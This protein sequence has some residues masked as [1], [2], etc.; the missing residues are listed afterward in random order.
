[1][2]R[3]T[4]ACI[5]FAVFTSFFTSTI[6]AEEDQSIRQLMSEPRLIVKYHTSSMPSTAD[7]RRSFTKN[8]EQKTGTTLKFVRNMSGAAQVFQ[9]ESIP[10][11]ASVRDVIQQISSDPRVAYVEPD[12]I[13]RINR[14]PN[15]PRYNEQ[16]HYF[17][18][19][20]GLNLP[21]AWDITTGSSDVVVA[22]IDTGSRPHADLAGQWVP[23]YDFIS[24]PQ[25]SVDGDGRDADP[26][27][28]GDWMVAG[29]CDGV[30]PPNDRDSSW[31]GTHV[32][33]TVAA[34]SDNGE[35]VAGVAW[36]VK[37]L[38]LRALGKC[39]G[40]TSDIADAIRWAAGASVP[41][42]PNNANP[43]KVINMSLGGFGACGSTYQQAINE[44]RQRGAVVIVAAGNDQ[45]DANQF[46]PA[47]CDNVLTVSA[48][49]RNAGLAFYSN[50]GSI[51]DISAPGGEGGSVNAVLSTIDTGRRFPQGDGYAGYQGTSM[52][53]PHVAGAAALLFSINPNLTVS[54]VESILT[55]TTRPFPSSGTSACST[56]RCGAGILDA[57]AAVEKAKEMLDGDDG[58]DGTNPPPADV[59][60]LENQTP[61]NGIELARG[62]ARD[63]VLNI[64]EGATNLKVTTSGGSG[65]VDLYLNWDN[66]ASRSDFVKK[67]ELIGNADEV[68]ID[69]PR[70]GQ[71]YVHVFAFQA[72]QE[73]TLV[74]SYTEPSGDGG[75]DEDQAL[76]KKGVPKGPLS[77]QQGTQKTFFIKV[78]S[79]ASQ[80]KIDLSGGRGD[81]DI[82]VKAGSSVSRSNFD[83]KSER[84]GNLESLTFDNPKAG[85]YAILVYAYSDYEGAKLLA[86]YQEGSSGGD[87]GEKR[88]WQ[89]QDEVSIPDNS[90]EGASSQ[91]TVD[92]S[93]TATRASVAVD[94][95]HSYR[96]DLRVSLI[97]PNGQRFILKE[98]DFQPG[99][100]LKGT[101]N[102]TIPDG[103]T[104][105]L[106]QLKVVDA[107][108]FDR[109]KIQSWSITFE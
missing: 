74:A 59:T 84:I 78:P 48:L 69:R 26:S 58:G 68:A 54:Q 94:I 38:P 72:S 19:R 79:G 9:L 22:V 25:V 1:M 2:T 87:E 8:L 65:D 24:F 46:S 13:M 80:L 28:P 50:Y 30:F 81:A 56:S 57:K 16:W 51:V 61:V 39:G 85:T 20:A 109:G 34:R 100:D 108:R 106:W 62:A 66:K 95:S 60:E 97:A 88:T 23:G 73:V 71:A 44:A 21:G 11:A 33:G 43:A 92:K 90:A 91:I 86:D 64:P 4:R 105:G 42:V 47:N 103:V 98:A 63:F 40:Y 55:D 77:G 104:Q 29:E 18:S 37:L 31:H 107:A 53:T 6:N 67:S 102:V 3:A 70:Y 14:E 15:D 35:G 93:L 10:Q 82:Y 36:G 89:N 49:D 99:R 7:A 45:S 96:G 41:G 101:F 76:L 75:N 52:A 83:K 12:R 32:A 17:E 5:L 27:D